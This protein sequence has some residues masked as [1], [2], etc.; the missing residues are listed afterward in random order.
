M[1]MP[2]WLVR[3]PQLQDAAP[4]AAIATAVSK[5]HAVITSN[6]IAWS[7]Q[8]TDGRFWTITQQQDPIGYATL[9]PLPGLPGLFEL[10]G[11]IAPEFQRQGAGSFLWRHM[12]K[13]VAGTA[14]RQIGYA[15]DSLNDPTARFLL[16]HQFILEHEEWTMVL[17]DL[18][19]RHWTPPA[20]TGQLQR[21]GRQTAVQ[22]LPRLYDQCFAGTPWFQPYTTAEIVATW[23]PDDQLYYLVVEGQEIGF[24]WLH[25]PNPGQA[26]I[27]PIGIVAEKQSSGYGRFL[28]IETLNQ[29]Q[30]QGNKTVTLGV[31]ANNHTANHLY[32][33]LGFDHSS[34]SYSLAYHAAAT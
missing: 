3:P 15:V 13:D 30:A 32:Q 31:W 5:P 27:E 26:E 23:E 29:L 20:V 33:S 12:Q 21:V 16:R 10:A 4:L 6:Q 18:N 7:I 8:Q 9:L 17:D 2:N 34:S 11:G 19:T 24:V 1:N 14:V 22:T 25:F 28:L